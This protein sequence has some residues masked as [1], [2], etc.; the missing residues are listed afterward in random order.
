MENESSLD[1]LKE[2]KTTVSFDSP[3]IECLT[4]ATFVESGVT[5]IKDNLKIKT[6]YE[7]LKQIEKIEAKDKQFHEEAEAEKKNLEEAVVREKQLRE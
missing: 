4:K 3:S 1:I 6:Q 7:I 5:V 2:L